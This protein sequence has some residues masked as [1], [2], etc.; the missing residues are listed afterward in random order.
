MSV[1]VRVCAWIVCDVCGGLL[2]S[3]EQIIVHEKKSFF[4]II[5][6]AASNSEQKPICMNGACVSISNNNKPYT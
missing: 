2:E 1:R 6:F 5:Y 3:S 4:P